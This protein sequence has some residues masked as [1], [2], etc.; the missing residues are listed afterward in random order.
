MG[1]DAVKPVKRS[2]GNKRDCTQFFV[3]CVEAVC[4]YGQALEA[5]LAG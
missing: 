4:L 1:G 5:Y 3:D 2:L